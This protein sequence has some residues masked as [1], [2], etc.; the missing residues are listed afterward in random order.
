MD[1]HLHVVLLMGIGFVSHKTVS[2]EQAV[3]IV[4]SGDR[5]WFQEG[6]GTPQTLIDALVRRSRDLRDVELCHMLTFGDAVYTEPEHEGHFRHNGLFLGGNVRKAVAEGRADYTPIFLSEIEDLFRSDQ[7]PIDVAFIQTSPPDE[8]GNLSLG[9][10]I[11]CTLTAAK[12]AKFVVA[13]VNRLMPRT[14]GDS[15]LH[16]D[17]VDA[18][19]ETERPL[20]E[21]PLERP[22]SVQQ[23]I[24]ENVA[25][26]IPDGAVLQTGIGAVPDAVLCCLRDRKALGV[27]SEMCS[28]GVIDLIEAGVLTGERKNIHTGKIVI[29]FVLG[30]K[31]LFDFMHENPIFEMHPTS[32]TNDPFVI[33]QNDRMVAINSAI[34]VDLTG[35]VCADSIG[36][37]PY[38]GF[39]GQV[40]FI[41]GAARSK[42]GMPI[43][44]LPATACAGTV[45]RIAPVLDSGAGVVTS[46][47]DVH[48]VV[49][50]HGI[51]YL[52][53]KTLRQRAEALI[54]IA[55]PRFRNELTDF[56]ERA[57][58]LERKC[59]LV[60]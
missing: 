37:K 15:S 27:H 42:G 49:T 18:I 34:Q 40:D 7:L 16:I 46:R 11:D 47:A 31:R 56:A 53:G 26:L 58:Y 19:V 43:I 13:E 51:A 12:C 45:S 17:R 22:T 24:A 36:T 60:A 6:C 14:F 25:S 30:T 44:A 32:Y 9:T 8:N 21:L 20:F 3:S 35:Q 50:E 39:G 48:Y 2:A 29:G 4:R 41:R 55:E 52:H 28:D 38:S 23:R 5:V 10:S 57:H 33:S 1:T 59:E 54:G